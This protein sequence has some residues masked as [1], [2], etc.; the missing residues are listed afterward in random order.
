MDAMLDEPDTID[1]LNNVPTPYNIITGDYST[2][3]IELTQGIVQPGTRN[4]T[5]A[6]AGWV[7]RG[8]A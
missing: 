6:S 3:L 1:R 7:C 8:E 5:G 4:A 2:L